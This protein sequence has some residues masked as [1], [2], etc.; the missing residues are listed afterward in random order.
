MS[1]SLT[2]NPNSDV[3]F[4]FTL[5]PF[6]QDEL[7]RYVNEK[8]LVLMV[9]DEVCFFNCGTATNVRFDGLRGIPSH[10][11]AN[12]AEH[13]PTVAKYRDTARQA[14]VKTERP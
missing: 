3:F 10:R 4:S 14:A 7:D 1:L 11:C 2:C 9:D 12:A 13:R 5:D 6:A 8:E